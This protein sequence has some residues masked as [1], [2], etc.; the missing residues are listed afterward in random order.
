MSAKE[1]LRYYSSIFDI[2]EINT[3]FYHI[4][5][6]RT[7]MSWYEVTPPNFRFVAKFPQKITHDKRLKECEEDI[8]EFLSAMKPLGTK[9]IA[10]LIQLPPS[11]SFHEAKV[12]LREL[13]DYLPKRYMYP[14]EGRHES[15]FTSEALEFLSENNICLVWNDVKNIQSNKIT[16]DYMYL[17]LIGNRDIQEKDFGNLIN[18]RTSQIKSWIKK[19]EEV[20]RT[21]E[22]GMI[23]VNNR[24]EGFAPSTANKIR[25]FLGLKPLSWHEQKPLTD[26]YQT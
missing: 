17:R 7:V 22:F 19:I 1:Y 11:L 3:T 26:Y 20:N 9:L 6:K 4:P 5:D 18:D 25:K 15:W 21:F 12:H 23:V 2:T 24:Y 10:M 14:V 8:N 16:S 13:L